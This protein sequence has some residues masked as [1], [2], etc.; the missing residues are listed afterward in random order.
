MFRYVAERFI[1]NFPFATVGLFALLVAICVWVFGT[2]V[3][4][5][6]VQE[7][8]GLLPALLNFL[9]V[10]CLFLGGGGV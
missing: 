3:C 1:D 10:F 2:L 5:V 4:C 8:L 7:L 9:D 6:C